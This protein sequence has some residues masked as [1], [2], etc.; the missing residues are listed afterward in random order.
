MYNPKFWSQLEDSEWFEFIHRLLKYSYE[1]ACRVRSNQ[2]VLVHCSGGSDR[3]TQLI[4]LAEI[5][6]DPY[7]RTIKGFIVLVEKEWVSFGHEFGTRNGLYVNNTQEDLKSPIFFQWLDCVHQLLYQFPHLFEFNGEFLL[8][9]AQNSSLNL[10]GTFLF[11]SEKDRTDY[12]AKL[13]TASVW[14]D[15]Y[16]DISKYKNQ[17]YNFE[18][19]TE[20]ISPNYAPYKLRL[21]DEYFMLNCAY[22]E[23][24]KFYLDNSK[25]VEFQWQQQFFNYIKISDQER[26]M[27]L[28]QDFEKIAKC[29]V[30]IQDKLK[31][32]KEFEL[33][34]DATQNYLING[35]GNLIKA[36]ENEFKEINAKNEGKEK[37]DENV[38]NIESNPGK[39]IEENK[40]KQESKE[41]E[42]SQPPEYDQLDL[43]P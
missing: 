41:N 25:K 36:N 5:L 14:T 4:S 8:F 29:L 30:D 9:L 3:S 10:Y 27:N 33:L 37:K 2:N 7:Y 35:I 39:D 40:T 18:N 31:G 24:D 34:S 12:E 26:Y 19:I 22:V 23:N 6:L 43:L 38:T 15:I 1:I 42:V 16:K 28:Q 17:F 11:N 21:W 20:F 13:K 32:R